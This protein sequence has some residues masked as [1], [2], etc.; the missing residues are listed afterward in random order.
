MKWNHTCGNLN[1]GR[2]PGRNPTA[3]R[4]LLRF[5]QA[6]LVRRADGHHELVGGAPGDVTAAREWA[7]LFAHDLV[8]SR[9]GR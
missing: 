2:T 7:S 3:D 8:F 4:V 9:A 5:G 1:P 6:A